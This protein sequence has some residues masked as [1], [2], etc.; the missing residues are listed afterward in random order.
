MKRIEGK[1][2]QKEWRESPRK[3]S[4][5]TTTTK[6]RFRQKSENQKIRLQYNKFVLNDFGTGDSTNH[7]AHRSVEE[8]LNCGYFIHF[9]SDKQIAL[10]NSYC[11]I[12]RVWWSKKFVAKQEQ[13]L[14]R[15]KTSNTTYGWMDIS[16]LSL[17]LIFVCPWYAKYILWICTHSN[18]HLFIFSLLVL[19]EYHGRPWIWQRLP[20]IYEYLFIVEWDLCP[21]YQRK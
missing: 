21:L 5:T 1:T 8:L 3:R 14:S 17:F 7:L 19:H 15:T 12:D 11:N 9:Q 16:A 2:F 18:G 10:S 4:T 6:L 13:A 20:P